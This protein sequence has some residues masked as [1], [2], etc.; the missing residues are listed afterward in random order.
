[1]PYIYISGAGP[2]QVVL[3]RVSF[4]LLL[5]MMMM[6]C[7]AGSRSLGIAEHIPRVDPP[8]PSPRPPHKCTTRANTPRTLSRPPRHE[9]VNA[10]RTESCSAPE[11]FKYLR[12]GVDDA[13]GVSLEKWFAPVTAHI[14]A[15]RQS[16]TACLV[17][18]THGQSRS[19]SLVLAYLMLRHN[20]S[21]LEAFQT[22]K[23]K[24]CVAAPNPGCCGPEP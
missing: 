14:D 19:V 4:F 22:V 15:A 2:A 16:G 21:L 6:L 3:V 10:T 24:R 18:C 23:Q 11:Q 17:H 8:L 13:K 1:L 7:A 9:V 20:Q 5:L 12:V